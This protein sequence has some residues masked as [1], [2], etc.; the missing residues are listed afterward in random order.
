LGGLAVNLRGAGDAAADGAGEV[1]IAIGL[2]VGQRE[3]SRENP[4]TFTVT[5]GA[6]IISQENPDVF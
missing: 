6:T 2:I 4:D 1:T 5:E 3:T